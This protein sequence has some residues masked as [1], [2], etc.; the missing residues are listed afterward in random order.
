MLTLKKYVKNV[1]MNIAHFHVILFNLKI[2]K[3]IVTPNQ[4]IK[5]WSKGRLVSLFVR[6]VQ[7][8]INEIKTGQQRSSHS[9]VLR[10]RLCFVIMTTRRV[11][12]SNNGTSE[13]L[14]TSKSTST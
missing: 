6:S 5:K 4:N 11:S 13:K 1:R 7:Q 10:Y 12:S 8:N 2:F 14:K 3:E 9:Q